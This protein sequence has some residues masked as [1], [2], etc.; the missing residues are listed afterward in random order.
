MKTRLKAPTAPPRRPTGWP[1]RLRPSPGALMAG[2]LA[3]A[4]LASGC[5][6]GDSAARTES[7]PP[8]AEAAT[9][10]PPDTEAPAA[11][12]AATAPQATEAPTSEAPAAEAAATA[13]SADETHEEAESG[14]ERIVSISPTATEMLFAMGAGD[15]VVAVDVGSDY[16]E[17]APVSEL[18]G[19]NPNVEAIAGYEPDLVVMSYDPGDVVGGLTALGVESLVQSAAA[20]LDDV[21]AQIGELGQAAGRPD[22]AE[23]LAAEMRAAIDDLVA[24]AAADGVGLTYYHELDST[25]YSVTASTFVGGIY[26][27]FGLENIAD[28]ADADGAAFGY[29]QLSDEYLIDADPDL[30]FL[31]DTVCCGQNAATVAERPGWDGLSAVVNGNVVE[32]NDDIASRWGPR[33]VEFVSAIAAA[34][35]DMARPA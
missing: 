32:L 10:A 35:A 25:Y 29:P 34:L 26:S 28:A 9:T 19:F 3:A 24:G 30:I 18:D 6:G 4:L 15:L 7:G 14:P 23:A 27:L 33:L 13:P 17:Q 8:A 31:A 16:P 20:S 22:G 1:F 11:E 2:L 5:S 21:Y 12:A